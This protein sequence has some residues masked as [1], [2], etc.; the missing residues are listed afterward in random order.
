MA[1]GNFSSITLSEATGIG[2]SDITLYSSSDNLFTFASVVSTDTVAKSMEKALKKRTLVYNSLL[3]KNLTNNGYKYDFIKE[4]IP[5]TDF[6][7]SMIKIKDVVE[8]IDNEDDMYKIFLFFNSEEHFYDVLYDKL[9]KYTPIPLLKEWIPTIAQV[10]TRLGY[11]NTMSSFYANED[12]IKIRGS[13][14]IIKKSI[15]IN[16]VTRLVSERQLSINGTSEKSEVIDIVDGLDSYLNIFGDILAERIQ[17]S[18]TPKFNPEKDSLSDY[19]NNYDDS[20]YHNGIDL[21]NA[22]KAAMEACVRN[23]DKNNCTFIIG[24]MGVGNCVLI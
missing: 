2:Y 5:N 10:L 13:R 6:V 1:K 23:L 9:Y 14:L 11:L 18:F 3:R 20:C 12:D 4:K 15:L 24:E 21:Y 17:N 16:I 7:H 8:R 22:Q 19:V